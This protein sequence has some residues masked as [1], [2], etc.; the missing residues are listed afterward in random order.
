MQN[1]VVIPMTKKSRWLHIFAVLTALATLGL[2]GLGGLVTSKEAGM[3]VP[4]WPT[5]YG[6]NMFAL[7]FRFWTGGV[8]YEHTHRLWA[9][10]VGLLVVV[11]VRWLGGRG[12]R[13]PLGIVGAA[14]VIAGFALNHFWPGLNGAG[15]FLSGIGSVVLLAAVVWARH[16]PAKKDLRTL[17]WT[18]F[19][20]VQLQGL[21]GGL[22]VVLFKDQIGILHAALAQIFFIVLCLVAVLTSRR[23]DNFKKS[24]PA[25]F[26]RPVRTL[27]FAATVLIFC[28]LILGAAMRHQHAGLAVRD[29]PLAYG[30]LWPATDAASVANYNLERVEITNVN[31]ITAFQVQLQMAHRVM[32][33]LILTAVAAC[34]WFARAT[35]NPIRR[36]ANFWCG[37][38][39][40]QAVLGAAT[41]LT[42][43]AA[44]IATLHV[45]VGALS[46]AVGVVLS[47][48]LSCRR[49]AEVS[50]EA[51]SP[52]VAE[53]RLAR[54]A[55]P[56]R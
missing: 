21:L 19:G 23:W 28:Q 2:I 54:Q 34:A 3:S 1:D 15:Y 25:T 22:R 43:K 38:I 40:L 41:V 33:L 42:N 12:A 46:L 52:A 8:F 29:F 53:N 14:E 5:S 36:L 32:A 10:T 35:G 26:P 9:S 18:A 24:L 13:L 27:A 55:L 11:L 50:S 17:G 30:K 45:L 48:I 20:L 51:P 49:A 16:E 44:D 56:A 7:P 6:Y 31:P 47:V 37:L 4:D 39:V